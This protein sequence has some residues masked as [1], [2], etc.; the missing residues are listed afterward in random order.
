MTEKTPE[1]ILAD[2]NKYLAPMLDKSKRALEKA[3]EKGELEVNILEDGVRICQK[4]S[5]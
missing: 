4:K 1:E 5:K 3:L 2:M